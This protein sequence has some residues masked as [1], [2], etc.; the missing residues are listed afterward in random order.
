MRAC[1]RASVRICVHECVCMRVSVHVS[2]SVCVCCVCAVCAFV[3]MHECVQFATLCIHVLCDSTH[4]SPN[5]DPTLHFTRT[6][7]TYITEQ[8]RST[9][10]TPSRVIIPSS[11]APLTG[12]NLQ[13]NVYPTAAD[14]VTV[15]L[16]RHSLVAPG[17]GG[18]CNVGGLAT[19][20]AKMDP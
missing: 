1:V 16:G 4:P 5:Q 7:T 9:L 15:A 17:G 11:P 2:V 18:D 10:S 12:P 8:L 6:R 14:R 3:C 19:G 13:G 20:E